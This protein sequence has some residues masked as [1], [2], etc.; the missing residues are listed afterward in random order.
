M[1]LNMLKYAGFL[2]LT[3]IVFPVSV[4][5][6]GGENG[7]GS[8]EVMSLPTGLSK[9][10]QFIIY[11]IDKRFEMVDK[12]FEMVMRE[13]DKRFEQVDKRF[14]QVDKRFEQVDKRF[15]QVDKRFEQMNKRFEEV[16]QRF[17]MII[18]LLMII[19]GAFAG[20]VAVTIGFAIWDRR[21]MVRPFESK[22]KVMEDDINMLRRCLDVL[23]ELSKH[24]SRLAEVLRSFSLL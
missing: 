22:I 14:E 1:V 23:R 13:M 15:E 20:I 11:Y 17:E 8:S 12:R 7:V 16:N 9:D 18:Q 6:A 3:V 24:D 10:T 2:L 5:I 21:T 4:V 19:V